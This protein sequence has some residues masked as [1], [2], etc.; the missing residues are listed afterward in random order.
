M[1]GGLSPEFGRLWRELWHI[2]L[3]CHGQICSASSYRPFLLAQQ[4]QPWRER[5]TTRG[6]EWDPRPEND[7]SSRLLATSGGRAEPALRLGEFVYIRSIMLV[8]LL[9]RPGEFVYISLVMLVHLLGRPGEFVYIR[10]TML[11]HLLGYALWG[12]ANLFTYV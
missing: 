7:V 5:A 12:P 6:A 9:G 11:V 10:L 2:D 8:H 4:Q 1:P 3:A